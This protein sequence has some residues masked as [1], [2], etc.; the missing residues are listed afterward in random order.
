MSALGNIARMLARTSFVMPTRPDIAIPTSLR[1]SFQ[2]LL[3]SRS[4][5]ADKVKKGM[6]SV[7]VPF[8]DASNEPEAQKFFQEN[9]NRSKRDVA[10]M[11]KMAQLEPQFFAGTDNPHAFNEWVAAKSVYSPQKRRIADKDVVYQQE[12]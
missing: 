10:E 9:R 6:A 12:K 3:K 7:I 1:Q 5:Y 4:S 8:I 11:L 2:K